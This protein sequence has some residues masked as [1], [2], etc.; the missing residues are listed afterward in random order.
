MGS[1]APLKQILKRGA[2]V[3]AANW[4]VVILQFAADTLFKLLLV[5]PVGGGVLLVVLLVGGDPS[6]LLSLQLRHIVP[7]TTSVLLAQPAALAAFLVALA[8]VLTGGA[9]LM[10]LVKAGT[11]SILVAGERSAGQIEHPPLRLAAI[12]RAAQFSLDQFTLGALVFFPRFLQ[13][14]LWL[15]GGY[16]VAVALYLLVVFGPPRTSGWTSA[17]AFASAALVAWISV[18]NFVYLQLQIA[19]VAEDCH[20]RTA[21]R[22]VFTTARHETRLMVCVFGAILALVVLTTAASVLATAALGLIAF[23]PLVSLAALPLQILAWV[24]RGL[25][26]QFIGLTGLVSYASISRAVLESVGQEV[27]LPVAATG[28]IGRSA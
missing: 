1:S 8:L 7:A 26:F 17:A 9:L 10:F 19:V 14:G 20:L 11:V 23:V 21:A 25:V 2:L 3:T 22:L 5:V 24:L 27:Q 13:L 4:P 16:L 6:D 18:L 12:A 15:T 28:E